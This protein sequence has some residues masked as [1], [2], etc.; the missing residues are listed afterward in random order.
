MPDFN[1][2]HKQVLFSDFSDEEIFKLISVL[3]SKRSDSKKDNGNKVQ[4]AKE[5]RVF[6]QCCR[7]NRNYIKANDSEIM[8]CPLCGSVKVI[9]HGTYKGK[10]RY[11]CKACGKTFMDTVGTVVYRSK[12]AIGKWIEF[13]KYTLQGESCR[14]IARNLHI[15]KNT[16]LYNRHRICSVIL[17]FAKNTDIFP[18]LVEGDEYYYPLSFKDRKDPMFFLETLGRMPFTHRNIQQKY[19]YVAEQGYSEDFINQLKAKEDYRNNELLAFVNEKCLESMSLFS[20]E[21][22]AMEKPKVFEVLKALKEQQKKKRG[23]SN[24]QVCIL[25]CVDPSH[26]HYLE[27]VCVGR[28][29]PRHIEEN[30]VPHLTKGTILVTDSHRAY[31]TV[32]SKNKIPLK[33][34]PSGK[35]TSEGFNLGHVNGYHHNISDFMYPYHGVSTKYLDYYMALFYWKEKNKTLPYRNQAYELLDILARQADKIHLHKFRDKTI[36]FDMK[37]VI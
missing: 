4:L 17:Q 27:P 8:V 10:Q 22:N 16:V 7:E 15:N 18:S 37:G 31:K 14:T 25:T 32:A 3:Q 26:N 35:H 5:D 28:I 6:L 11:C 30:L 20:R 13:I 29:E 23:I 24:Q 1:D 2:I 9:K 36:A 21:V 33:Q 19:D 34:I 12:M